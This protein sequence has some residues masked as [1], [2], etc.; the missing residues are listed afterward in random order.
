MVERIAVNHLQKNWLKF[1][2]YDLKPIVDTRSQTKC[3][4]CCQVVDYDKAFDCEKGKDCPVSA[5]P[6]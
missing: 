6:F 3:Y 2:G 5:I 4:K 1:R